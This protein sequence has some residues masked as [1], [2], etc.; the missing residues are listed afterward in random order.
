MKGFPSARVIATATTLL[1]LAG[2]ALGCATGPISSP[3]TITY[4]ASFAF[5]FANSDTAS[6]QNGTTTNGGGLILTLHDNKGNFVANYVFTG[7]SG[8]MA[9]VVQ[10]G[11]A[12]SLTQFGDPNKALGATQKYL[13]KTWPNCDFTQAVAMP[14]TGDAVSGVITLHG[15]LTV[16]CTYTVGD[17]QITVPTTLSETVSATQISIG[18]GPTTSG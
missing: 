5:T 7:D 16:P 6:H 9:G 8:T 14:F 3:Q 12:M 15:G 1:A 2:G 18:P 13:G 17:Q 11:G 4:R 10:L